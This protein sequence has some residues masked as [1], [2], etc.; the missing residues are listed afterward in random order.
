MSARESME[1]NANIVL[2]RIEDAPVNADDQP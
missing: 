1:E 2:G